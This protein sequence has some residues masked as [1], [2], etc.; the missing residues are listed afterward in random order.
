MPFDP[1][2]D[3]VPVTM[4]AAIPFF[5]VANPSMPFSSVRDVIAFARANPGKLSYGHAGNGTLLHL[6]GE[7]LKLMAGVDIVAVPY[8]GGAPAVTGAVGGEIPLAI[9]EL[10]AVQSHA[11]AGRLRILGVTTARRVAAAPDVPTLAESGVPGYD[12]MGWFGV[13][14]PA[15]TPTDIVNRWNAEIGAVLGTPDIRDRLSAAGA[16]PAPMSPQAFSA[17]IRDE[18]GKWARVLKSPGIRLK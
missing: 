5:L 1:Q 18:T 4:L 16:E 17:V 3:L 10:P 15:R 14:A 7:L 8:K 2:K 12:T 11:R 6:S 9:A 13:V